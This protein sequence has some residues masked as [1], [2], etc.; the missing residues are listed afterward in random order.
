LGPPRTT[1][2][3]AELEG[4][5]LAE[6]LANL[7]NEGNYGEKQRL[8]NSGV[9]AFEAFL[10]KLA[11]G[12]TQMGASATDV[13]S[14]SRTFRAAFNGRPADALLAEHIRKGSPKEWVNIRRQIYRHATSNDVLGDGGSDLTGE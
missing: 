3:H 12:T 5:K 10:N 2:S 9:S 1:S 4:E 6:R 8:L 13:A 7:I 11:W 14:F